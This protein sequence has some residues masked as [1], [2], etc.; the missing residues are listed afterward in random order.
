[1]LI[2]SSQDV[3]RRAEN[4][5]SLLEDDLNAREFKVL[6]SD[7]VPDFTLLVAKP[8]FKSLG[9]KY[10]DG[11]KKLLAALERSDAAQL[12]TE[13]QK[14]NAIVTAGTDRFVLEPD[15]VEFEESLPDNLS[16]AECKIGRVYV[17]VTRTRELE[18][19]GLVRDV[20]RRIQ[21]MRKEM[22][23]NVEQRVDLMIQ[24]S[25]REAADLAGMF[26]DHLSTET[27]SSKTQ[28]VGPDS[29]AEWKPFKY[30]KEWEIEDLR[31]KVG[32]TAMKAAPKP[33]SRA[34]APP[35]KSG[36]KPRSPRSK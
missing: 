25:D 18:A 17:D 20:I 11:M 32:M 15:D 26:S 33:V 30:V 16:S 6:R 36:R 31:I 28:L 23:L 12:R 27:R 22:N 14:G 21:V 19:E 24:F 9:P 1:M 10:R 8:N 7:V 2:P 34:K 4:L 13:L 5:K 35:A 3:A 29:K